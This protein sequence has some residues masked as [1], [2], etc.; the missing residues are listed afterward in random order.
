[1]K[2]GMLAVL[3]VALPPALASARKRSRDTADIECRYEKG[4]LIPPAC[5]ELGCNIFIFGKSERGF[6][7]SAIRRGKKKLVFSESWLGLS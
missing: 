1:M 6:L 5:R 2:L 3:T 7:W 4:S